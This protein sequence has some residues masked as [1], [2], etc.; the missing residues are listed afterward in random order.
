[1]KTLARNWKAVLAFLLIMAAVLVY[2]QVYTPKKEAYIAERDQ[3]N[4]QITALQN[5]IAEN[6]RYKGVQE[7]LPAEYEKLTA[8]RDGLYEV[9]PQEIK[10]E[11]QIMYLLY[12]ENLFNDES[13]E[14]GFTEELY[15]SLLKHGIYLP[16][17]PVSTY[18]GHQTNEFQFGQAQ[19]IQILSD[20]SELKAMDIRLTYNASYD[21]FKRMVNYLATDS[22]VTSIYLATLQYDVMTEKLCGELVLRL[23]SLDVTNREYEVPSIRN[24]GMGKDNMFKD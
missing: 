2:T 9:F 22:R 14:L 15:T 18:H 23:Y 24:P 12:L 7:L 8:S 6:E 19:P 17:A 21:G 1:M 13:A 11:D 20:G 3:L 10:E 4:M 16:G 5:T